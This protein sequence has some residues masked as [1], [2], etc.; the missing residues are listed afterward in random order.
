MD[1]RLLLQHHTLKSLFENRI[2]LAPVSLD[3]NDK[4]LEIGTGPGGL[5]PTC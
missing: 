3:E 2:L 5:L 4:V 1:A